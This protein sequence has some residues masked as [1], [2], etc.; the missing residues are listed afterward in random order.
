MGLNDLTNPVLGEMTIRV[1][2][3][4]TA[5]EFE[6]FLDYRYSENYLEASDSL[7]FTIDAREL[8]KGDAAVLVPGAVVQPCVN[9]NVQSHMIL[10]E[11]AATCSRDEG[12][13]VRVE[14]RDWHSIFVDSQVDPQVRFVPSM[15][16]LDVIVAAY[17]SVKPD[18]DVYA[19]SIANVNVITGRSSSLQSTS[20]D[21]QVA[22]ATLRSLQAKGASANQIAQAQSDLRAA[23]QAAFS[24]R[25]ALTKKGKQSKHFVLG[26][27]KPYP[28]E[29]LYAFVSRVCQRFGLWVRP[30][31]D[32]QS[33]TVA[34][35]NFDQ[36]ARYG[37]LHALDAS[38]VNNNVE[39]GHF[40]PNR[41]DQPSILFAS[42]FGAGGNFAKSR[43]RAYCLNPAINADN[44][45]FL[46]RYSDVPAIDVSDLAYFAP[47][48]EASPRPAFLYDAESHNQEQLEAYLRRELCLRL[49]KVLAARYEIM[50]HELNGQPVAVDTIVSVRDDQPTAQWNGP[51]WVLARQ[52]DKSPRSGAK[53]TL[54]LCLP[55]SLAF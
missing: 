45:V 51:L 4:S 44:S 23:Q 15:T 50:G 39:K 18:I 41:R 30:Q 7:S 36:P 26:E 8:S 27:E 14:C 40:A 35:P 19:D 46:N 43:L 38:S 31:V 10:D 21:V 28:N 6:R 17:S 24:Q 48:A 22:T 13:V 5:V 49:R 11:P 2:S 29:G 25:A 20:T 37:L 34:A 12:N 47:L 53:T 54:D 33:L 9:G 42:G 32:G 1:T 3:G 55:G 52:F 16:V